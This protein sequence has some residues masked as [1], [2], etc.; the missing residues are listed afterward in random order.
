MSWLKIGI[1]DGFRTD[2]SC[3]WYRQDETQMATALVDDIIEIDDQ[4]HR[5]S[6]GFGDHA[7]RL[8]LVGPAVGDVDELDVYQVSMDDYSSRG[9]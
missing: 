1:A 2:G 8:W 6:G 3:R 5:V 4:A 9:Q 7:R